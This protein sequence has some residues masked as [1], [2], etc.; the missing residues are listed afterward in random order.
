MIIVGAYKVKE[1]F[2]SGMKSIVKNYNG[3]INLDDELPKQSGF[4]LVRYDRKYHN[5]VYLKEVDVVEFCQATNRFNS[6]HDFIMYWQP[7][8]KPPKKESKND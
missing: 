3:W 4:Y 5:G 7:L 1:G 6:Y 2:L 8:P